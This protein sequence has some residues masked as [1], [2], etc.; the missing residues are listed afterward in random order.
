V[1]LE[2][3]RLPATG[4]ELDKVAFE[5][6]GTASAGLGRFRSQ[7]DR[8]RVSVNIGPFEGDDL[9]LPP[10][11]EVGEASEV[12]QII[13]KGR[14]DGFQVGPLKEALPRVVLGQHLDLRNGRQPRRWRIQSLRLRRFSVSQQP[15]ANALPVVRLV[16]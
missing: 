13:G 11:R 3:P 10:A 9:A 4:N 7:S 6:D 2:Q 1:L 8:P 14:D 16:R 15:T 5:H 12:P